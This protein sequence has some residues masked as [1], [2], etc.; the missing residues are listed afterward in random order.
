MNKPKEILELEQIYGITL[1][2]GVPNKYGSVSRNCYAVDTKGVVTQLNLSANQ[3]TDIKGFEHFVGLQE[4]YL[5]GNQL[6][7]IKGLEYL[8]GL[9]RLDLSHNQL[10]DIKGMENLV[11]LQQ[12]DL[13]HNQLMDIKVLENL[14]NLQRLDLSYNQLTDIKGLAS[15][16]GYLNYLKI[17]NNFFLKSANLL[18]KRDENNRDIILKYFSDLKQAKVTVTLPAKVMLLGNHATGK[19]AFRY[20]MLQGKFIKPQSTPMLEI[21][22]YPERW[23]NLPKAIIFDFGGQDYYH[24]LYQAFFSEDSIYMLFWCNKSNRNDVQQAK[25]GTNSG[26]RNF[27][28]E[29]WMHQLMYVYTKRSRGR[30]KTGLEEHSFSEQLP[31]LL[32]Q[33]HADEKETTDRTEYQEKVQLLLKNTVDEYDISLDKNTENDRLFELKREYVK[34][35]LLGEIEKKRQSREEGAYYERFLNYILAWD[36]EK[37]VKVD[38]VLKEYDREE[39][40]EENKR[41]ILKVELE[42]LN[43]KGLVLYYRE[44]KWLNDV[45]WLNPAKTVKT[46]YET[47]LSKKEVKIKYKGIVPED[48]FNRLCSD[49]KIRELLKCEKVIFFDKNNGQGTRYIVPGY[50]PLSHEYEDYTHSLGFE[51]PNFTLK[52]RYFIPFGLINQ[53]I[54]LYGGNPNYKKFWRDQLIFTYNEEY[55]LCIKLDFSQL[56]ITVYIHP[57]QGPLSKR[58][59]ALKEV[60]KTIYRNIL[61]LYWGKEINYQ[62]DR[63]DINRNASEKKKEEGSFFK[64]VQ[65]YL[66]DW[67][68]TEDIPEDMYISIDEDLFVRATD[69]EKAKIHQITI[70]AY[71]LVETGEK[72]VNGEVIKVIASMPRQY[73]KRI[74]YR[75]FTNNK[76]IRDMK[77]IFIS[78]ATEDEE[79]KDEFMRH[80]V[81]M[82]KNGLIDKP[83]ACSDIESGAKWDETIEEKLN[84]CDILICLVSPYYLNSN[85]IYIKEAMKQD[86]KLIPIIVR[87]CDWETSEV[88]GF[89][90][91]LRAKCITLDSNDLTEYTKNERE[92]RWSKIIKEMREKLFLNYLSF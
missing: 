31:L 55:R 5:Y 56:T 21:V 61:D 52:F 26:I 45:V 74:L 8:V 62:I 3:L 86:K 7:D 50:L 79:Y 32:V 15:I 37:C 36:T 58:Q 77:K 92:G 91:A 89:Q 10:M 24:G 20:Y 38:E 29:Y 19:T 34:A 63:D 11:G 69:L 57:Q 17:N 16:V 75:Y 60:E 76:Y 51:K 13:S 9:Q 64:Q 4:L 84:D 44:N 39:E 1:V 78:F 18:L 25:D 41:T 87:A 35:S 90:A 48:V 59:L 65:Q 49:K 53:L 6:T 12:L 46:I 28:K 80:T 73:D 85:Y 71:D 27:T 33:T 47:V 70:P 72:T 23:K 82:Q 81:T 43:R 22:P 67:D 14:V 2:E 68:S 83:F 40:N 54:C 66:K 42:M 30:K 88:G